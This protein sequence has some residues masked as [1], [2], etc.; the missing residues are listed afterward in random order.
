MG[1]RDI[2]VQPRVRYG[3]RVYANRGGGISVKQTT[4]EDDEA[5]LV[6]ELDEA[7]S[8]A[9]AILEVVEAAAAPSSEEPSE[10]R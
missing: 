3:A 4:D 1:R 9:R 10:D 5:W 7:V 6:F 2:T 8:V